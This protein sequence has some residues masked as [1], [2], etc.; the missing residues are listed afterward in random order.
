MTDNTWASGPASGYIPPQPKG[1]EGVSATEE[2]KKPNK[3]G[4][5]LQE[6]WDSDECKQIEKASEEAKQRAVG[7]YF[8]LSE[9][10]KIDMVQA[11]CY[12]MCKA[13]SEGTS[14]RGL[15][16]ALGIYPAGF[17]VD[18]LM[19]VHNAL[20]SYY[21]DKKNEQELKGDVNNLKAFLENKNETPN[22]SGDA[23]ATY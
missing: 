23:T 15:Q 22:E 10:D 19:E 9:S 6:W 3:F 1:T 14:H 11:I 2:E 7:K 21:H 16:D 4:E 5:A 17:W 20:W 12:I 8:M 13:E 18:H